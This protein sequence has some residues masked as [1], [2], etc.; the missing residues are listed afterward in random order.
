MSRGR[1]WWAV[2]ALVVI[3]AAGLSIRF[4]VF[5]H[6]NQVRSTQLLVA[7]DSPA[8]QKKVATVRRVI[9]ASPPGITLLW[10]DDS[11]CPSYLFDLGAKLV[12]F[13]PNPDTTR[14]EARYAANYASA[15]HDT[16]LSVVVPRPQLSRAR[17]RFARCFHGRLDLIEE[18]TSF[19]KTLTDVPY[20]VGA[21]VKALTYQRSC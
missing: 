8:D 9:A 10:S 11:G 19:W 14:G 4:V 15:H 5:P 1:I 12:C 2:V 18:P 13:S 17:T 7:V 6:A 21:E 3:V 16:E 20:Q